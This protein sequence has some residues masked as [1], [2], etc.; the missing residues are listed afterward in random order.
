MWNL[1][2]YKYVDGYIEIFKLI[3]TEKRLVVAIA[4]GKGVGEMGELT[5]F[6]F[7]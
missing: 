6:M 2:I 5:L 3:D 4:R 1:N 7:V